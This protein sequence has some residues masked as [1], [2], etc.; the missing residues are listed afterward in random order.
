MSKVQAHRRVTLDVKECPICG[1]SHAFD[2]SALVETQMDVMHF[3][4]SRK[5]TRACSVSC[6][7]KG[8]H[9]VIDVPITLWS[10]ETLLDMN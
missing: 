7:T 4:V 1:D 2:F 8:K 3:M 5:E 6:P 10:G 9:F